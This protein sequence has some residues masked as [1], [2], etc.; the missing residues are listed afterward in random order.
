MFSALHTVKITNK[1]V[2]KNRSED[3]GAKPEGNIRKGKEILQTVYRTNFCL[4]SALKTCLRSGGGGS[5][6]PKM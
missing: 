3:Q 1:R 2:A 4:F 6:N 5:K